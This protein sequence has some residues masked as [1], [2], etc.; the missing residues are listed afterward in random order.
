MNKNFP[1]RFRPLES[2]TSPQLRGPKH[3][4]ALSEFPWNFV[5]PVGWKKTRMTAVA[6][7]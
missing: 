1:T 4:A 7:G 6:E 5:T 2:S 3:G